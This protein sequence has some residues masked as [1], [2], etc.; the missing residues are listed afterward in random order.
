MSKDM[1]TG[2]SYSERLRGFDNRQTDRQTFAI[3]EL[4]SQLK[5]KTNYP[6]LVPFQHI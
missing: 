1:K 2:I 4:L 3:V 5:N 6:K